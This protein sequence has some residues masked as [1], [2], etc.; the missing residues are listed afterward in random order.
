MINFNEAPYWGTEFDHMKKAVENKMICGDGAFT[1]E[2]NQWIENNT[3]ITKALLTTSCTHAL[4]MAALLC[5]IEK[6][7]EVIMPSFTFVSTADAFVL[8]GA[9]IVFVDIR[10]DTMN[11]DEKL[12]EDAIT[13]KTKAIV[14]VHYAGVSCYLDKC[15]ERFS[16]KINALQLIFKKNLY[17]DTMIYFKTIVK[18]FH[19]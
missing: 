8:R 6:G 15:L 9:K 7:D 16:T 13:E 14:P 17:S 18:K 11:I 19:Q 2:C 5:N 12:I 10:P 1:K 3:G 4:E